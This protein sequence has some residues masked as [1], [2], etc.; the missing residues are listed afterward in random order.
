MIHSTL[1][2][3]FEMAVTNYKPVLVDRPAAVSS[4]HK[5]A[6]HVGHVLPSDARP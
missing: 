1:Y 6:M 5:T 4:A 3:N 2:E